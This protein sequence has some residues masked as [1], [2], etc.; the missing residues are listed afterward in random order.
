MIEIKN[1]SKDYKLNKE[2]S[3][4]ALKDISF[5]LPDTGM[6]FIVGKSGSGKS[7]LLNLIGGLDSVTSG[8]I[9][10]DGNDLTTLTSKEFDSYRSSY[11]TFIFQDYKL[12]DGLTVK[13]NVQVGLDII[14]SLNEKMVDLAIKKVGLEGYQN[15]YPYEL[16]GGQQ[17]RVAI[18]RALTRN[19]HLILAD[20]PTG[21]LDERTSKQ[22]LDVLKAIS[23][24]KLVV[25][26]SHNLNDADLYADRII[27]LHD[28]KILSDKVRD[29]NYDNTF[30]ISDNTC[31]LPHYNDITINDANMLM[32]GL[33]EGN[34]TNIKQID[35]GF[36]EVDNASFNAK[37]N[38]RLKNKNAT[39]RSLLK[40][41]KMFFT[42]K[43][44][45]RIMVVIFS[46]MLFSILTVLQSFINF[47]PSVN[48]I[49]DK[50]DY[51]ILNK[52]SYV[53]YESKLHTSPLYEVTK[54]EEY[55]FRKSGYDGSVYKLNNYTIPIVKSSD[56]V[57][58]KHT[59]P[60]ESNF[61]N[62]FIKY[63]R[64]PIQDEYIL[65][66]IPS[67]LTFPMLAFSPN[68]SLTTY[69]KPGMLLAP[70]VIIISSGSS[71]ELCT[72]DCPLMVLNGNSMKP[73]FSWTG[74]KE[75]PL[76]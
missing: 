58:N 59:V 31:Y 35:N 19:S 44:H 73:S 57:G 3:C 46:V 60:M 37:R 50:Y 38:I 62:F 21:N 45:N 11:L 18:A 52:G 5:T 76:I 26:V 7:T 69:S 65:S 30:S 9:I 54:I 40:I 33:K 48:T 15:R 1:L 53:P 24:K 71:L 23:K 4:H 36:M 70:P 42:K 75:W 13:Q 29:N 49:D 32:E 8:K 66:L 72:M 14:N 34:I 55:Y 43:L 16:S 56:Y 61:D 17:Q 25:I 12:F 28:G 39:N 22:I 2:E 68:T 6:V 74:E 67:I 63:T 47:T 27:E 41:L 20:E 51:V 10:A 64:F